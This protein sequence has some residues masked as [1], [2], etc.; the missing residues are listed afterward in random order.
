MLEPVF[1]LKWTADPATIMN[2][3]TTIVNEMQVLDNTNSNGATN[4]TASTS[5]PEA[6]ATPVFAEDDLLSFMMCNDAS[7]TPEA[8]L[9]IAELDRYLVDISS[10]ETLVFWAANRDKY[11]RLYKLHLKHHCIPA[12]SAAMER[13]F[14]H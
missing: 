9:T 3:K 11:P 7:V 5:S 2:A 4:A 6:E 8:E 14:S 1:K 13:C 10:V 12:T